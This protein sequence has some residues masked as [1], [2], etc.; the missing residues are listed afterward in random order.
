V[1]R[2]SFI[3]PA[4][5]ALAG[6]TV[7]MAVSACGAAG[8]SVPAGKIGVV[9]AENEY[10][11]VAQQIGGRYVSVQSIESNPN[12]DPHDYEI[13][14]GVA[15]EVSS[16]RVLI[17]N[18]VGYDSW[19]SKVASASPTSAR[20]VINAQDLLHLPIT[21]PNPHLWYS[22]LTMPVVAAA[23]AKAFAKLRPQDA[24]YFRTNVKRF[25]RSLNRWMGAIA[26][27]NANFA[28]TSVATTEPVADYV[29]RAMDAINL[30]PFSLQADIM[31]GTDPSPQAIS[32]QEALFSRH[33][34][35]VFVHN[36]QVTDPLTEGFVT[37]ARRA[38][39]PVVGVYETMPT[40]YSY[41]SWMVAEV[42]AIWSAV[43]DKRSTATL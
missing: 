6:I 9:A 3:R 25:D 39:I 42:E 33:L 19:M 37:D 17:E 24:A 15:E 38:G 2:A 30:T 13:S 4:I 16:A 40:G 26:D 36:E 11:N 31:N 1:G 35:K 22:P 28:G 8:G 41:Q 34:V 20:Q 32:D 23:M 5:V 14:P 21:T 29:L 43:A 18:G 7:T 12:T 27:F 10:G